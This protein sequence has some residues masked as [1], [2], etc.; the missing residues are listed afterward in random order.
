[1]LEI[2]GIKH[3]VYNDKPYGRIFATYDD[4]NVD[5]KAVETLKISAKCIGL[6][7]TVSVGD[8]VDVFYDKFGNV[9]SVVNG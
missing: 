4:D 3:G 7:D 8:I 2:I 5:G 9:V 6:L 1:M